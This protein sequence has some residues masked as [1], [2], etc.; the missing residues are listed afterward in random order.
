MR[1]RDQV[2]LLESCVVAWTKQA[3]HCEPVHTAYPQQHFP[4]C[5]ASSGRRRSSR[6]IASGI[7][8]FAAAQRLVFDSLV[9]QVRGVLRQ[10]ASLSRDA[11]TGAANAVEKTDLLHPLK[12]KAHCAE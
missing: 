3:L 11:A 5:S 2:H 7:L 1:D 6:R 8:P 10:D 4:D 12:V 9:S